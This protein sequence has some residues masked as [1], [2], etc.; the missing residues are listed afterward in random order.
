MQQR[1]AKSTSD[2]A[3]DSYVDKMLSAEHEL[4]AETALSDI[5]VTFQAGAHTTCASLVYQLYT[6]A[7]HPEVQRRIYGQ[8]KQLYGAA[9]TIEMSEAGDYRK[10]QK[11]TFLR[12]FVEEA[13]RLPL[14]GMGNAR[15]LAEDVE[16]QLDDKSYL[17]P[18]GALVEFNGV[19]LAR[20][21]EIWRTPLEFDIANFLGDDAKTF[22]NPL[23]SGLDPVFGHGL[24]N[25]PAR[26]LARKENLYT[27]AYL[28][29]N[30]KLSGPQGPDDIDFKIPYFSQKPT[31]P[32]TVTRR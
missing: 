8:L 16:V 20:D 26:N 11:A 19:A 25:C 27:I 32:L 7:K 4:D 15:E 29:Y 17:L 30:F 18:K 12:A 1:D 31:F 21:D 5:V 9:D 28:V 22:K 14:S 3:E 6:L 24:R 2:E 13:W 10:L 23:G